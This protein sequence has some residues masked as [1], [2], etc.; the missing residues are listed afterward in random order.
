MGRIQEI[1]QRVNNKFKKQIK[2]KKFRQGRKKK[3]NHWQQMH[4]NEP[5]QTQCFLYIR[6]YL[7]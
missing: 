6:S 1:H 3:N 5:T 7:I 2:N 4:A